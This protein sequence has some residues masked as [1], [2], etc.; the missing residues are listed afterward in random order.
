MSYHRWDYGQSDARSSRHRSCK[1]CRARGRRFGPGST[2]WTTYLPG[3]ASAYPRVPPCPGTPWYRV[4]DEQPR[5]ELATLT[6]G[7][8][9]LIT[10]FAICTFGRKHIEE[11][12]LLGL[13][14][15]PESAWKVL[16]HA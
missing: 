1:N 9:H 12:I 4:E 13:P 3:A 5:W 15:L 2:S 6:G 7:H 10:D 16:E 8:S 11:F 14:P